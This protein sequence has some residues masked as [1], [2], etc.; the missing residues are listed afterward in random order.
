MRHKKNINAVLS[1]YEAICGDTEDIFLLFADLCGSTEYK[2]NCT[3]QGQ[4]VFVWITRQLIFLK[5]TADII[6]KYKGI[7]VKTIGDAVFAYFSAETNPND[8]L[9]CAVEIIQSFDNLRS[10]KER[11]K[12]KVKISVDF[13]ST[14]NGSIVSSTPFDPI[15]LP[16]DRCARLISKANNDEVVFSK[17]FFDK[18]NTSNND[19]VNYEDKYG[20][21]QHSANFKGLGDMG[22]YKIAAK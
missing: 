18:L 9:K 3:I 8:V 20:Y 11:S 12:I 22:F 16:A 19:G 6:K 17:N 14:Y 13:G 2:K 5:R 10:F 4:P 21:K 7:V 15:G 1:F